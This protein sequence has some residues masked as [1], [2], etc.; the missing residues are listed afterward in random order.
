MHAQPPDL[1]QKRREQLKDMTMKTSETRLQEIE[2]RFAIS[3]LR[4]TYS[5]HTVRG[6]R[7]RL[8]TL[9]TVDG[10]FENHRAPGAGPA[11]ATGQAE[12]NGYFDHMAPARRFPMVMNEV[13]RIT[14]DEAEGTC[15]MHSVGDDPFC[16]HYIDSFRRVDGNWLFSARRFYPYWPKFHPADQAKP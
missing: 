10:V 1:D 15:M 16:G 6:D 13:T 12:L 8:L 9:F 11:I 7:E 3:E 14:G 4:S 5:W 2:D